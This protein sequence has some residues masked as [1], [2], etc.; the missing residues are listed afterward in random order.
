MWGER[1]ERERCGAGGERGLLS[2]RQIED[3]WGAAAGMR[4]AREGGVM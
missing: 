4:P 3:M 1:E 2:H